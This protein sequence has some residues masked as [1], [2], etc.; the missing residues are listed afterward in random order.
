MDW[1]KNITATVFGGS[2]DDPQFSAYAPYELIDDNIVGVALPEKNMHGKTLT[3]INNKTGK[4]IKN[5]PVVDIG[6][7]FVADPYWDDNS[8][9]RAESEC[10]NQSGIDLTTALATLLG[11]KWGYQ[12]CDDTVV[13]W[14]FDN[15]ENA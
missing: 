13:S 3:I 8:R 11:I 7:H 10:N 4:M 1:Q 14:I 15:G 9:P 5:V 2:S 12:W 6:P